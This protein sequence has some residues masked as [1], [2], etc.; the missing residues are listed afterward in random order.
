MRSLEILA[1]NFFQEL[2]F[3]IDQLVDVIGRKLK[4]VSVSY[5]VSR[6]SL[7][8]VA[9]K[10]AARIVDVIDARVALAGGNAICGCVFGRFDV[11]AVRG[12][13]CGTEETSD[14]FFQPVL[15]AL[16]NM[17]TAISRLELNRPIGINFRRRL[18]E[19][20][21]QRDAE[22]LHKRGKRCAD[23]ADDRCHMNSI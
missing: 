15:V 14:A 22:A 1:R 7:D 9:A 16:Q 18:A 2:F 19:H 3:T 5:S 13:R 12:A 6:A 10:N 23:F 21:L 8:T 20:R 17:N 11:N 4:V